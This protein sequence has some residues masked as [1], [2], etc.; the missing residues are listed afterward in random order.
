MN[1]LGKLTLIIAWTF[2]LAAC[3]QSTPNTAADE[4]AIQHIQDAWYKAYNAGDGGAVAA[5]YEDDAV[6]MAPN[7]PAASGIAAIR[8]YYSKTAPEF[9]ASGLTAAEGAKGDIGISGDLAWQGYTYTVTDRAGAIVEAG[10][11]LT[12]FRRRRDG[13]W[14]ILRDI[15]NA[16]APGNAATSSP[17]APASPK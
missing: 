9:Q 12:L 8:D 3:S 14:M 15:W 11:S 2:A 5:L 1:D 16:D 7:V 4:S 17:Q 6:V 10:K 13:K